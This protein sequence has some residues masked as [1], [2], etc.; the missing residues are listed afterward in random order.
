MGKLRGLLDS[1]N[2]TIGGL[3]GDFPEGFNRSA[4]AGFPGWTGDIAYMGDMVR[5]YAS[6]RPQIAAQ[7]FPGTTDYFAAQSGYPIPQTLSGQLG[8]MLG[9]FVSPSPGDVAKLGMLGGKIL[10]GLGPALAA[11]PFWHGSPHKYDVADLSKIDTGEGA[12]AYGHGYYGAQAEGT[13]REYADRLGRAVGGS[14]AVLHIDG[15]PAD[16]SAIPDEIVRNEV[17]RYIDAYSSDYGVSS[18]DLD[19]DKMIDDIVMEARQ[20]LKHPFTQPEEI[21]GIEQRIKSA[22]SLRGRAELIPDA[23]YLYRGEYRWPDARE[24]TDPLSEHHLLDWDKP[25]SEQSPQVQS[26]IR[27]QMPDDAWEKMKGRTGQDYYEHYWN[28]GISGSGQPTQAS[29]ALLDLGIPG[30]R[31]LDANSRGAGEGTHNYVMFDE[32]G[33]KL[34]ERNGEPINP[35]GPLDAFVERRAGKA[36]PYK[37][38]T[39]A[40]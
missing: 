30:I 14:E 15:K 1:A 9:G 6:G 29:D 2:E 3:L 13:A 33:I 4:V 24:A 21:P 8:A 11:I 10:G 23:Q 20:E 22:E 28:G 5:R 31:Y 36:K 39:G 12:Q 19:L 34:L 17:R 16:I 7:D 18:K 35:P 40:Q 37:Q 27:K 25:L 38:S 32:K 26:A